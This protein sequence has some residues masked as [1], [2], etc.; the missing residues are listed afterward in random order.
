[1][2]YN[3]SIAGAD[4]PAAFNNSVFQRG[5]VEYKLKRVCDFISDSIFNKILKVKRGEAYNF[6]IQRM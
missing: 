4:N 3:W 1:V 5:A 6:S 2:I